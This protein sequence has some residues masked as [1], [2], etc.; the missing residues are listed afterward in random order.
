MKVAATLAIAASLLG[1][2]QAVPAAAAQKKTVTVTETKEIIKKW[3]TTTVTEKVTVSGTCPATSAPSLTSYQSASS[4]SVSSSVSTTSPASSSTSAS[5]TIT[6]A[7]STN[8]SVS[9]TSYPATTY[10]TT[11]AY[12]YCTS[13]AAFATVDDVHPRLFNYNGTGASFFAGTNAWWASHILSNSDVSLVMNDI[14]NVSH[15][16]Q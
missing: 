3:K 11:P 6:S 5:S 14:K 12:P 9:A 16:N 15:N 13:T 10:P 2:V 8:S 1:A 7:T 4:S